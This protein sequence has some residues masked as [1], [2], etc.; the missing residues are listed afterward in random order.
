MTSLTSCAPFAQPP[1]AHRRDARRRHPG[2]PR[3]IAA[4][5]RRARSTDRA[6]R[7]SART[8]R[9]TAG[10]GPNVGQQLHL[11]TLARTLSSGSCS[12]R[13]HHLCGES[14]SGHGWWSWATPDAWVRS[15]EHR[16]QRHPAVRERQHHR[17]GVTRARV[18]APRVNDV[19]ESIANAR[20]RIS[21]SVSFRADPSR[22]RGIWGAGHRLAIVQ[23]AG[24]RPCG[25]VGAESDADG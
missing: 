13:Q 19:G 8:R 14:G 10:V 22:A 3:A 20:S 21:S 15:S 1:R 17:S 11:E 5:T 24:R 25:T 2:L 16:R 23:E 18:S 6:G 12:L 7:G 4:G 9:R